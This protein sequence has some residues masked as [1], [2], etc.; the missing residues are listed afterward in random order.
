MRAAGPLKAVLGRPS[1]RSDNTTSRNARAEGAAGT[2]A[3]QVRPQRPAPSRISTL[4]PRGLILRTVF[5]YSR[6]W[7]TSSR[8]SPQFL[9]RLRRTLLRSAPPSPCFA[10]REDSEHG[11]GTPLLDQGGPDPPQV[12]GREEVRE[13]RQGTLEVNCQVVL[14][15]RSFPT[16]LGATLSAHLCLQISQS[17]REC[18]EIA[19]DDVT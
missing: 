15:R 1:L 2:A 5:G 9:T 16:T 10:C 4:Y 6:A 12:F 19:R 11:I 3:R 13:R 18:A 14:G 8:S 7:R 17:A